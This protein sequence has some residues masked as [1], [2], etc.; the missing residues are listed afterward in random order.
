MA[1]VLVPTYNC[2]SVYLTD[3]PAPLNANGDDDARVEYKRVTDS[4]WKRG[5]DAWFDRRPVID[6]SGN[7]YGGQEYRGSIVNLVSNTRYDV[8][9]TPKGR[10]SYSGQIQTW[11]DPDLDEV[12]GTIVTLN[13]TYTT[14]VTAGLSSG[15]G[16]A[17]LV[18]TQGGTAQ[19]WRIYKGAPGGTLI[20]GDDVSGGLNIGIALN[21]PYTML[22]GT[23]SAPIIIRNIERHGVLLG[24]TYERNATDLHDMVISGLNVSKFGRLA[25]TTTNTQVA[26]FAVNDDS[27]IYCQGLRLRRVTVQRNKLHTPNHSA[28]SWYLNSARTIR[29]HPHG[30]K[31]IHFDRGRRDDFA[32]GLLSTADKATHRIKGGSNIANVQAGSAP[33]NHVIRY[34]EIWFGTE[35]QMLSTLGPKWND[36]MGSGGSNGT[37]SG[38]LIRDTD[39]HG[40]T[41]NGCWDDMIEADGALRNCRL[42][43][44]YFNDH[45]QAISM[46]GIM[47]GPFYMWRNVLDAGRADIGSIHKPGNHVKFAETRSNQN[48][49]SLGGRWY[50][51]NNASL[52]P[53]DGPSNPRKAVAN[54]LQDSPTAALIN[55]RA[56]NNICFVEPSDPGASLKLNNSSRDLLFLNRVDYNFCNKFS[57]GNIGSGTLGWTGTQ[58]CNAN[59]IAASRES[60]VVYQSLARPAYPSAAYS[61]KTGNYLLASSSPGKGVGRP[62]LNFTSATDVDVGPGPFVLQYGT[63]AYPNG[64]GGA[65]GSFGDAGFIDPPDPIDEPDGPGEPPA[66]T[67]LAIP[68]NIVFTDPEWRA[69]LKSHVFGPP[70]NPTE[71]ETTGGLDPF[72]QHEAQSYVNEPGITAPAFT[73]KWRRGAI[74]LLW[75]A[76]GGERH[77]QLWGQFAAAFDV[78]DDLTTIWGY[79][80]RAAQLWVLS[81]SPATWKLIEQ[82]IK[83]SSPGNGIAD[84]QSLEGLHLSTFSYALGSGSQPQ[85][86][87]P[88]FSNRSNDDS[89][90]FLPPGTTFVG[91]NL[92]ASGGVD[93]RKFYTRWKSRAL[94]SQTRLPIGLDGEPDVQGVHIR[95]QVR[96]IGPTATVKIVG[97]V[98]ASYGQ[99][100][101]SDLSGSPIDF[102]AQ[103]H[104]LLRARL[105]RITNQ[106]QWLTATTLF[107][108]GIDSDTPPR[109][110]EGSPENPV[111]F[112]PESPGGGPG[113]E[114]EE[115][116]DFPEYPDF[117]PE[118][119]D[120]RRSVLTLFGERCQ[121][122]SDGNEVDP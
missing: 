78:G 119:P 15:I 4:V 79:Q 33:G 12:P 112:V 121:A 116:I 64:G 80:I 60:N 22:W 95:C 85:A 24:P 118:P 41:I 38:F 56:A 55:L 39:V 25:T 67:E 37:N 19:N 102:R 89:L 114:P 73:E 43:G 40:N 9:I 68:Q 50:V 101:V 109:P 65:G 14:R 7:E 81:G 99:I 122:D 47:G 48:Y 115:P 105:M 8:K 30:N 107:A 103:E 74:P 108:A 27:S 28:N 61:L 62:L 42:W 87:N 58:P 70:F 26:G 90:V 31:A 97:Q 17:G 75:N 13:D 120:P 83:Q 82:P 94:A 88:V 54:W 3:A 77:I 11:P 35:A 86:T 71:P 5:Y 51:F 100:D 21:A 63:R 29:E 23:E 46:Q 32:E 59:G 57:P 104:D 16:A 76:H 2:I 53:P 113:E 110:D 10:N 45:F 52:H 98:G 1:L 111:I 117:D 69:L 36:V 20:D 93:R 92:A 91:N 18:I 6:S 106:W 44:S 49:R 96:T 34:N 84:A 66:P 72:G